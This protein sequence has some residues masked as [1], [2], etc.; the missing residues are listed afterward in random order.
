MKVPRVEPKL[1]VFSFKIQFHTQVSDLRKNLNTINSVAD[2]IRSSEKLKRIMQ[3][4]LSLDNALNH[5]T[6]REECFPHR[7]KVKLVVYRRQRSTLS[8]M[9]EG[10]RSPVR[11]ATSTIRLKNFC[12]INIPQ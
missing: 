6:A 5:G 9:L 2:E 8:K 12:C 1:R 11:Q 3:T 4:I 10:L 7:F